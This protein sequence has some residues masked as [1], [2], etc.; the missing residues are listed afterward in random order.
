[1]R[2]LGTVEQGVDEIVEYGVLTTNWG[3]SPTN[4]TVVVKN[5]DTDEVVTDDVTDGNASVA[6]NTI[7]LPKIQAL[8]AE[9][10][11]RVEVKFDVGNHT[12]EAYFKIVACT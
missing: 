8:T 4:V 10:I 12:L 1:M 5:A 11:Y 6:G 2:Y 3:S 9:T 7:T